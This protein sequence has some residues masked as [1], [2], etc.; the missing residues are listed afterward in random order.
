MMDCLFL[1]GGIIFLIFLFCLVALQTF[2]EGTD[3]SAELSANLADLAD[4]KKEND[5]HK[6]D[7]EFRYT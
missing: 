6:D 1:G 7:N 2:A 4:A 3:C 5:D